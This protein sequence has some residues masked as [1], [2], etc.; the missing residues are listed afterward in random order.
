[1]SKSTRLA[2]FLPYQLSV[3]SNAVSGRISQE[4]RE[5]FGL[6]VPEWRVMAVLEKRLGR[7]GLT[8]HP[9][10]TRLLPFRRPPKTQQGG[11]GPATFDFVGFTFYWRRTRQGHWRMW[12]KTRRASLTVWIHDASLFVAGSLRRVIVA[13]IG[14]HDTPLL[15]PG[16]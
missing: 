8:L 6:N 7:F 14:V 16:R 9:D 1:M 5:R 12:C 15:L 10:K 11:K 3:T 13:S 4:Y 2:D